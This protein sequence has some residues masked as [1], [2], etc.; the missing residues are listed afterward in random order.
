MAKLIPFIRSED[1]R[2]QAAFYTQALGGE[3]L[4]VTTGAAVPNNDPSMK[5]VVVNLRLIAGGI[6]FHLGECG[7]GPRVAGNEITLSLEFAT[8]AEARAAFENLAQGGEMHQPLAPAFWG[9]LFGAF[10]DK[11]GIH[12]T[13]AANV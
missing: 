5:D 12:W 13:I 1:A 4:D 8:E 2:A 7:I 9:Q 11:F 3:I 6:P 10:T